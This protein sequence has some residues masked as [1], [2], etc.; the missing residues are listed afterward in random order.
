MWDNG[1]SRKLTNL[2][3]WLRDHELSP[4]QSYWYDGVDGAQVHAWIIKPLGF[5]KGRE[6]PAYPIRALLDVRLGFQP[7]VSDLRRR[8]LHRR[9]LQSARHDRRLRPKPWTKATEGD[10]GGA[11]FDEIMLGVDELVARPYIDS[12]RMGVT[13]RQLRRLHDQLGGRPH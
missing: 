6:V 11:E 3:P 5:E 9:L 1:E 13:R 10:Q 4:P 7:R 12:A 2:N 8:R